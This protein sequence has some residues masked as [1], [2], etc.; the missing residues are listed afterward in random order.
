MVTGGLEGV[1]VS[2]R[3]VW[4]VEVVELVRGSGL[5]LDSE[6]WFSCPCPSVG[7]VEGVPAMSADRRG[8]GGDGV[9]AD[10]AGAVVGVDALLGGGFVPLVGVFA[11][12]F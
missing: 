12:S 6:T 8:D 1:S 5:E 2:V 4:R 11:L 3:L 9:R 7:P 10:A